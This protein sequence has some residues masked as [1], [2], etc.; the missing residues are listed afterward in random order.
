MFFPYPVLE[1]HL[2][3]FALFFVFDLKEFVSRELERVRDYIVREN[4]YLSVE[5]ADVRVVEPPGRV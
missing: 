1:F 5:V 2:H 3:V 4:L